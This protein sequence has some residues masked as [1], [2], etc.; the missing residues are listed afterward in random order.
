MALDASGNLYIADLDNN[1]IRK[2]S[3]SGIITT[4]AGNGTEGYS[5]D[6]GPA[7]SAELYAP[8]GVALDASG[9]LYIADEVNNRIRKVSPSGIITTVAGNGTEGYSGDN[10]PATSAEL[11][12]PIGVALDASGNLYIADCGQQSNPQGEPERN[13]HHGGRE[14]NWRFFWG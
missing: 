8:Y 2:V 10:G 7:T 5:G 1:R 14:W 13:H 4:V 6:N 11:D 3:P 9:N 12:G